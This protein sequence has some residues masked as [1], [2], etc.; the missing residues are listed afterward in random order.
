LPRQCLEQRRHAR[1]A[2]KMIGLR[3]KQRCCRHFGEGGIAGILD[4]GDAAG[5]PQRRE[6][7]RLLASP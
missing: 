5:L 2:D 1:E 7:S 6:T 3:T 4:D